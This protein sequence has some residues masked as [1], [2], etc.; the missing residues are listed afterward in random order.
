MTNTNDFVR[1]EILNMLMEKKPYAEIAQ[2]HDVTVS[3][4]QYYKKQFEKRG[5]VFPVVKQGKGYKITKDQLILIDTLMKEGKTREEI[6]QNNIM[7]YN[8]LNKW[9]GM[10]KKIGVDACLKLIA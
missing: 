2:K 7:K 10:I 6:Y 5:I 3:S 9:C 8:A 1:E 4:I